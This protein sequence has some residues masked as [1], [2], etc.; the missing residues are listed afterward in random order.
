MKNKNVT[1]VTNESVNATENEVQKIN[2]SEENVSTEND[3][4]KI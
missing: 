1:D 4:Q 3:E 2:V